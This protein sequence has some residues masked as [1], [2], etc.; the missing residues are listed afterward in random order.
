[1]KNHRRTRIRSTAARERGAALIMA[2][3]VTFVLT[4]LGLALLFTTSTEFQIAGAETTVNRTFYAADSGTQYGNFQIKALRFTPIA[5]QTCA[6]T[7]NYFCFQVPARSTAATDH[8]LTVKVTPMQLVNISQSTPGGGSLNI[9]AIPITTQDYAFT[10]TA[11]DTSA[12]INSQKTISV[13]SSVGPI[14]GSPLPQ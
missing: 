1:M 3:L 14:A 11:T 6:S 8:S 12:G 7:P 13:V 4:V 10:S 2:I 5:Y 9:G